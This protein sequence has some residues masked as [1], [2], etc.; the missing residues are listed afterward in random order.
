MPPL[1]PFRRRKE[2]T[3]HDV[4]AVPLG[5]LIIT[6][7]NRHIANRIVIAAN[8]R[9]IEPLDGRKRLIQTLACIQQ[10]SEPDIT[11]LQEFSSAYLN[12]LESTL[13]VIC[14]TL[15]DVVYTS[16]LRE[17]S[18]QAVRRR[19]YEILQIIAEEL[20][21]R[22]SH[23]FFRKLCSELEGR[24]LVL[25][26][27][28]QVTI[29]PSSQQD[30]AGAPR[31]IIGQQSKTIQLLFVLFGALTMMYK[32][33]TGPSDGDLQMVVSSDW[34]PLRPQRHTTATWQW[35]SLPVSMFY[36][37]VDKDITFD[38]FLCRY[39]P[40][41]RGPV[42]SPRQIQPDPSRNAQNSDIVRSE[43]VSFH[44]LSRLLGIEIIWTYSI[45]E[46]LEFNAKLKKLKIF[47]LPSFCVMLCLMEHQQTFLDR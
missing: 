34:I 24:G 39:S 29:P 14:P 46:H 27:S 47:R 38:D 15:L 6:L 7:P 8:I 40:S 12:Y 33:E 32:P 19:L 5:E 13:D 31:V 43:D 36:E 23:V 45:C 9:L 41:H 17:T 26:D 37:D 44:T 3:E 18:S 28:E 16:S 25:K 30:Q 10:D 22:E 2:A 42:P 20:A 21:A 4:E 1:W 35:A 11:A